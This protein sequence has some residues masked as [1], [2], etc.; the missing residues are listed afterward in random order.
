MPRSS[1]PSGMSYRVRCLGYATAISHATSPFITTFLLIHLAA[2]VL[3]NFGGSS[4]ASQTMLLGREY[5]QTGFGEKYLVLGP[6]A[7]HSLTGITKR[8]LSAP[9]VQPRKL[10]SLLSLSG[11]AVGLLLLP[12]HFMTHRVDPTTDISPI[13]AVGPSELDYEFVKIGLHTW[14]W[15]SWLLY[16]S[17]V[18]S[19]TVHAI[20]GMAI[21]WNTW[22]RKPL[23]AGWKR[24]ARTTIML[25]A[26][27][28]ITFPVLTGI[29][30]LGKEPLMTFA[31][32]AKR[33]QA[34]FLQ[35]LIYRI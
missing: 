10:S 34:S 11:Y 19:V 15:R 21:I 27:G 1:S 32:T 25:L 33:Y 7:V 30:S 31:S 17:L 9:K 20:D 6:L 3:A 22:L 23:S 4:L 28:G 29:Y 35:S 14:P 8:L 16:G 24:S 5:Y 13:F 18:T 2:P 12:I 26:L